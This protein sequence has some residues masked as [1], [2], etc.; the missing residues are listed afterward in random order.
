MEV[1]VEGEQLMSESRLQKLEGRTY[2]IDG[3]VAAIETQL[4]TQGQQLNRI[5]QHLLAP[6]PPVNYGV[7]VGI[8]ITLL[9]GFGSLIMAGT[10][11]VDVQLG[12]MR[13]AI[14]KIDTSIDKY[15]DDRAADAITA[16]NEA[17]SAGV[18]RG[19]LNALGGLVQHMD[20]R[21]HKADERIVELE[22]KAAAGEVSRRAIG[23][24]A[25]ELGEK[26]Q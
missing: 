5:E 20:E 7:W 23:D 3:K 15:R 11:Y 26:I 8:A 17:Y 9:F 6:K 25:K 22:K 4:G 1:M 2:H 10:S 24:Y 21:R 16:K 19:E 18:L 13:G 14:S 12:H